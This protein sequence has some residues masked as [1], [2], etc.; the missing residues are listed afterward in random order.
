MTITADELHHA[1]RRAALP[2]SDADLARAFSA[3]D[4]DGSGAVDFREFCRRR[5]FSTQALY[6]CWKRP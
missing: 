6:Q 2:L 1:A 4:L 5:E 3:L